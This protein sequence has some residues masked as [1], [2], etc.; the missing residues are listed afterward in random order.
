VLSAGFVKSKL[1]IESHISKSYIFGVSFYFGSFVLSLSLA[2]FAE[3]LR[4]ALLTQG[5]FS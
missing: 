1:L 3:H 5:F 2:G 4:S